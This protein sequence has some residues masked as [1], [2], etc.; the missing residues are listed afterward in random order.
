MDWRPYG[1]CCPQ[2]AGDSEIG[3]CPDCGHPFLRCHAFAEC[4]SLVTPDG[5]AKACQ[6][7]VAPQ[8]MID[9]RAVITA[10]K[11]DRLSIPLILM[12]GSTVG[13]P[14]WVKRIVKRLGD[15]YEPLSLTW[16]QVEARTERHFSV[17]VPPLV[18][19]GTTTA[20]LIL[21]VASRYKNIE[22]EYAFEAEMLITVSAGQDGNTTINITNTNSTYYAPV[23]GETP[24]SGPAPAGPTTLNLQPAE[25]YELAQGIRGYRAEKLRVPRHVE[26][27]FAGFPERDAPP[28]GATAM[29]RGRLACGRNSRTPDP[30][31]DAVPNDVCLRAYDAE[32]VVDEPGT[33]AISRHH[34]DLLVLNDRL[35]VHTRSTRG[36]ELNGKTLESGEVAVLAPGDRLVPIPGRPDKL[37]LEFDFSSS[38]GW[39]DR[40]DVSRT[41]VVPR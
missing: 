17:D 40:V 4:K 23:R 2:Y 38:F 18:D 28:A 35:C 39:V 30:G 29:Q 16:E 31:A 10:R 11:G 37:V 25:V 34:F 8:L 6:V 12:N 5:R 27:A 9:P 19:G 1:T 26:F 36:L 33:M 32:G 22:E 41:P 15:Q 7:C 21:V 24:A 3:F 13:R 20:G 14:L